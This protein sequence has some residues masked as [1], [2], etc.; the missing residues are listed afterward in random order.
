MLHQETG[1]IVEVSQD[2]AANHQMRTWIKN[3]LYNIT[4]TL[5]HEDSRETTLHP[6][7]LSRTDFVYND[8]CLQFLLL[9]EMP[10]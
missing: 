10:C 3:K 7:D 5:Y 6:A 1:W 9:F 2:E 8:Y 4:Y